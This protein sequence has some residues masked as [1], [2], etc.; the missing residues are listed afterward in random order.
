MEIAVAIAMIL[1]GA[2]IAT[3]WTHDI[4][5]A[6]K[7]DVSDGLLRARDPNDRSLLLPHWIAEYMTATALVG[8][9]IGLIFERGWGIPAAAGGLG[10]LL[11]TSLNSL[12]WALADP[13]RRAYAVPMGVGVVGASLG[14]GYLVVG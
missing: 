4:V 6:D 10:A 8:G 12:G 2:T 11:Y 13:T 14:L 9:A 3:V 7:L 1:M 5:R